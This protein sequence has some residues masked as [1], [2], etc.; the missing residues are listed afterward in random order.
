MGPN[1]AV[2]PGPARVD[3]DTKAYVERR[4]AEGLTKREIRRVLKRYLARQI[5]RALT[6]ASRADDIAEDT[7]AGTP[8]SD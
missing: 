5:H 1:Q 3:I 8:L 6:A 4:V 2:T 7:I